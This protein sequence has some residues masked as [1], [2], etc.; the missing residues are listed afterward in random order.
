MQS[1]VW[2]EAA[3]SVTGEELYQW[4]PARNATAKENASPDGGRDK[5]AVVEE[6][7]KGQSQR[8]SVTARESHGSCCC[9]YLS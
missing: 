8:S 4:S 9:V 1:E 7:R 2:R 6:G 3:G 5:R